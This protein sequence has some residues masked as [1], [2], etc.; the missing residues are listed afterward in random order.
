MKKGKVSSASG[1]VD[2]DTMRQDEDDK[3]EEEG[4]VGGGENI[5]SGVPP[6][7]GPS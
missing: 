1:V 2:N 5:S 4:K 6:E 3:G 7:R